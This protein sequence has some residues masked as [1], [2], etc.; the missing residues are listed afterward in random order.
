LCFC[1]SSHQRPPP[2]KDK[3]KDSRLTAEL[4]LSYC[5]IPRRDLGQPTSIYEHLARCDHARCNE[6]RDFRR[7]DDWSLFWSFFW[8]FFFFFWWGGSNNCPTAL[9]RC[10]GRY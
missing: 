1:S 4:A 10:I 9:V 8:L 6:L 5:A 2:T 3:R 7:P